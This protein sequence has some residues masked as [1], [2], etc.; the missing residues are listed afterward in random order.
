MLDI[1]RAM[2]AISQAESN[3]GINNCPRFEVAYMPKGSR[4][5]I[6]GKVLVGTGTGMSTI[7]KERWDEWGLA[8]SASYG[9]WQILY[10]VAADRGYPGEP[11]ALWAPE[12]SRI[13]VRKHILWLISRGSDTIEKLADAYNSGN[14][15][16]KIIPQDYINKVVAAYGG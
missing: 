16:D 14:S 9:P 11:W 13:W 1:E 8:S 10:Q 4:F 5:T 6:Q 12:V 15:K 3:G 2:K 7:A